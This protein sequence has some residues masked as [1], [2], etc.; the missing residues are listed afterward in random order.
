[1]PLPAPCRFAK[2]AASFL[3]MALLSCQLSHAAT[4]YIPP[5][6]FQ[7]NCDIRRLGLTQ[8]QHNEL[9]KIRTAFKMAGD[10]ARL[11]VM[12]SEHS[13]RRSVVEIISS[14]VFNRN[15]ARDYV[16]SRYHSSMDFAVDELEIQ[17]RFFHILTPQQQQMWLSSCLK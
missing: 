17:H 11:K 16:E 9:R 3:S 8:G 10:R 15:E 5:N 13:R 2:P 1:M 14:D 7:P 6:D 4:A 12:H